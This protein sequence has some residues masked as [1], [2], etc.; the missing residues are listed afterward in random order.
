M[1]ESA[2]SLSGLAEPQLSEAESEGW[3]PRPELNRNMTFRKRLLYPFELR[4]LVK[5]NGL[6]N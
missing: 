1:N 3:C 4:G 6:G 2:I 5:V